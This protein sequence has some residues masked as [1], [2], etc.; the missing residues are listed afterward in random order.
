MLLTMPR[1]H[2]LPW[3][4]SFA[5]RKHQLFACQLSVFQPR[6]PDVDNKPRRTVDRDKTEIEQRMNVCPQLGFDYVAKQSAFAMRTRRAEGIICGSR[7]G[8][9]FELMSPTQS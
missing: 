3:S 8:G 4:V 2:L 7:R 6:K 9:E 1:Q 5:L